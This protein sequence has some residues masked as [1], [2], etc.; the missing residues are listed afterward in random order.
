MVKPE[1]DMCVSLY[2]KPDPSFYKS[3]LLKYCFLMLW[4]FMSG[5]ENLTYDILKS[6]YF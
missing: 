1:H 6:L 4:S 2:A 5:K 3:V